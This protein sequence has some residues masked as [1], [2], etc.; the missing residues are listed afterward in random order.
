MEADL[1]E[2]FAAAEIALQ[3]VVSGGS[4][5]DLRGDWLFRGR[6]GLDNRPDLQLAFEHAQLGASVEELASAL[7]AER[8]ESLG[9]T[10]H[11][12]GVIAERDAELE[13][14]RTLRGWARSRLGR[15]S[16]IRRLK[17]RFSRS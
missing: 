10:A 4:A 1:F 9:Q 3:Q 2:E 16:R 8:V 13:R 6:R 5:D 12:T 14:L 11:Y 17:D 7:E 15:S